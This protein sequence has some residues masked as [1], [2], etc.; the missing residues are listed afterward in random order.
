MPTY[1]INRSPIILNKC[2]RN[3]PKLNKY[4]CHYGLY[5]HGGPLFLPKK[6]RY[7]F[8]RNYYQKYYSLDCYRDWN[9][10]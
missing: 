7:N 6:K 3:I 8:L 2:K 1:I 4:I 9:F 10:T 5:S